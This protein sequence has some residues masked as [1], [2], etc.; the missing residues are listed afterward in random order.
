MCPQCKGCL[1]DTVGPM[2]LDMA[3]IDPAIAKEL[4]KD[5]ILYR[6]A[7]SSLNEGF[8]IGACAY[9]RRLVEKYIN[10]LLQLLYEIKELE[11]AASDELIKIQN[12]IEAKDFTT[13]TKFAAQIAPT[14]ITTPGMNPLKT[15]HDQ[16]SRAL[17]SMEEDEAIAVATLLKESLDYV[18]PRLRKQLDDQQKF[19]EAMKNLS[20]GSKT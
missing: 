13:K 20:S 4:G 19:V 11:G 5:T 3:R 18:I 15:L 16:L 10:P 6:K 1:F 12:A 7:I 14:A 9:L 17:H 8:G 2:Q